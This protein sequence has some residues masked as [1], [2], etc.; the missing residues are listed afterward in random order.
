MYVFT[1]QNTHYDFQI[2]D[3]GRNLWRLLPNV[4]AYFITRHLKYYLKHNNFLH[5]KSTNLQV[6]K[7][8]NRVLPH[9]QHFP[10]DVL[11]M[12]YHMGNDKHLREY[13]DVIFHHG[14]IDFIDNEDYN[15]HLLKVVIIKKN[16][17]L[18]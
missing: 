18:E 9:G 10:G 4:H 8:H 17:E 16:E 12:V 6:F 11:V 3:H 13:L 15:G 1:I 7:D 14:D 2:P 5:F